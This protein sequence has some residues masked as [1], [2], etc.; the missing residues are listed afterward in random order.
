MKARK[1]I[2]ILHYSLPP[3]V[4]GVER[5]VRDQ[6]EALR[7]LGHEVAL[8]SSAQKAGF[9]QSVAAGQVDVA[10]VHNIFTMPFDLEWTRQLNQLAAARPQILWINWVHD[11][12]AVNPHYA[13]TPWS[14]PVPHA[15]HVAVSEARRQDYARATGLQ[16]IRVIPNGLDLAHVLALPPRIRELRLSQ[17]GLVLFHPARLVRRKNIELGIHVTAALRSAGEDALYL[18]SGAPDPHQP[19]GVAYHEELIALA[20]KLGITENVRFL[21]EQGT[22]TEAEIHAL[23]TAADTLFFPSTGE[24]FG[25]PLIESAAHRLPVWCSDLPVHREVLGDAA[26]F[27]PTNLPPEAISA[28]IM[29]WWRGDVSGSRRK[30]FLNA[31]DMLKN[32][33]EHLEPLLLAHTHD[34][35]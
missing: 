30:A 19:D 5:V 11:V 24:G 7:T 35:D 21:G 8:W 17:R 33:L 2:S 29:R 28:Q 16:N 22:L 4:G 31:H 23:Y 3:V 12:A 10:L 1:R 6:A 20:E 18:I 13:A 15:L 14:E 25:L 26:Y 32:C 27:F 9:A 34:H